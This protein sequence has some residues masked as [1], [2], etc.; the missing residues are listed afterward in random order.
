VGKVIHIHTEQIR[1]CCPKKHIKNRKKTEFG[2]H[3]ALQKPAGR[4]DRNTD[5][6]HK[7]L[8]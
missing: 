2:I 8:I 5:K 1:F 6:K 3:S 7:H 4:D